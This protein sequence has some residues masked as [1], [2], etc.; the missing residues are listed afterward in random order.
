MNLP[1]RFTIP[2]GEDTIPVGDDFIPVGENTNRG[3]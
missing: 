3:D 1:N 2:V